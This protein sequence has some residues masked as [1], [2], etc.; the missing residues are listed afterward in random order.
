MCNKLTEKRNICLTYKCLKIV[1]NVFL[2]NRYSN[3]RK[4]QEPKP[5]LIKNNYVSLYPFEKTF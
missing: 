3:K 5:C 4:G 2:F 1:I